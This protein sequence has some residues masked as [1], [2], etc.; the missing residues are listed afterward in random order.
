MDV[1]I[2]HFKCVQLF[3]HR[4]NNAQLYVTYTE[5]KD[6]ANLENMDAGDL[7]KSFSFYLCP[8]VA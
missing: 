1:L 6:V 8:S 5:N 4:C 7:E 2:S 3:L